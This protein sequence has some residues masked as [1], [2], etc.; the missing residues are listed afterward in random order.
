MVRTPIKALEHGPH[1]HKDPLELTRDVDITEH[2]M[3]WNG[4]I[5][6]T[7]TYQ[8]DGCIVTQDVSGAGCIAL[9]R[10]IMDRNVTGCFEPCD[11]M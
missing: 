1:T 3:L 7:W 11:I 8:N 2:K 9:G 4:G 5:M 6:G 10:F